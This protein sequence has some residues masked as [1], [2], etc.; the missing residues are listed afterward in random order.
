MRRQ[1]RPRSTHA[2]V[3]APRAY[4]RADQVPT[5]PSAPSTKARVLRSSGGRVAHH[6]V[7]P[8][9]SSEAPRAQTAALG[10]CAQGIERLQGREHA[11]SIETAHP[12]TLCLTPANGYPAQPVHCRRSQALSPSPSY[13]CR[14]KVTLVC[15]SRRANAA[16][17]PL[18]K[19]CGESCNGCR[20]G[21]GQEASGRRARKRLGKDPRARAQACRDSQG[22]AIR[23]PRILRCA[24]RARGKSRGSREGRRSK[25]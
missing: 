4:A 3:D 21:R 1:Q 17:S 16:L 24:R 7:Q 11:R 22:G 8:L 15:N 19:N 10:L 6:H 13:A 18:F 14:R 2:A 23:F 5:A 12:E 25:C 9:I 20:R